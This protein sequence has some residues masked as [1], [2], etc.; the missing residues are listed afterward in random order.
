MAE[1]QAVHERVYGVSP[2]AVA[3][4]PG[5]VNIVGAHTEPHEGFVLAMAIDRHM[6][7]AVT[8][9]E[10]TILHFYAADYD[11][12]RRTTISNLKYRREDRWANY[13]KGVV[14]A[15][16]SMGARVRG[17]S[18]SVAGD[19][20]TSVGLGASSAMS[21][22]CAVAIRAALD[23]PLK[24]NQLIE[25]VRR[26][27][28][29]FVGYERGI[30]NYLAAW[31][32]RPDTAVLVDARNLS[33]THLP[34]EL[35]SAQF[36]ITN[37]KIPSICTLRDYQ[38]RHDETRSCLSVLKRR[39]FGIALRDYTTDDLNEILPF[40]SESARRRC[41]HVFRE[42]ASVQEACDAIRARDAVSLGKTLVRSHESLRDLYEVSCPE[43]DWLVKRS[44]ETEGVFGARLCGSGSCG[45]VLTLLDE[46]AFDRYSK[47]LEDYERIF[48]FAPD[49]F[50]CRPLVGVR[51]L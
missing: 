50:W 15:L 22:A 23:L 8:P 36:A 33:L 35:G 1:I 28:S 19:I 17:L 45:A 30:A 32:S 25:C 4:A 37:A 24:D 38:A 29:N 41:L 18:I 44:A 40:V 10:D 26:A 43:I 34:L 51:T 2:T 47:R 11:E 20:P 39:R 3:A 21:I 5:V 31:H 27:E 13:P 14:S 12:R 9:R 48:G 16:L 49:A 42:N 6:Q 7:V 46:S